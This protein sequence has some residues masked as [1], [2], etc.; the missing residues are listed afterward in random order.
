MKGKE[1][2]DH[3]VRRKHLC[4]VSSNLDLVAEDSPGRI[5][6]LTVGQVGMN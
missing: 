5:V 4:N 1:I 3:V 6:E 2:L